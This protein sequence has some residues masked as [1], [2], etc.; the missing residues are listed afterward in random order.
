MKP[1]PRLLL[2]FLYLAI[3]LATTFGQATPLTR[4]T[5]IVTAWKPGQHLYV[6]GDLGLSAGQLTELE[7]WLKTNGPNWMIILLRNASGEQYTAPDG[8]T[9]HG[10]DAVERAANTG[11]RNKTG[12]GQLTDPRTGETNGAIFYLFLTERKFSYAG[13]EVHNNR[14]LSYTSWAGNLDQPAFRAMSG[15]GRIVDAVKGTV[16]E[17]NSRLTRQFNLEQ[18]RRQREL[19]N[20]RRLAQNAQEQIT[21]AAAQIAA[22]EQESAKFRAAHPLATGDLVSPPV[23][24]LQAKLTAARDALARKDAASASQEAKS[25]LDYAKTYLSS[26]TDYGQAPAKFATLNTE[27]SELAAEET[28]WG[29][30]RLNEARDQFAKAQAV[31]ARGDSAYVLHFQN[32]S[33]ALNSALQE[34]DRAKAE[35]ARAAAAARRQA[36][37]EAEFRRTAIGAVILVSVSALVGLIMFLYSLHQGRLDEKDAAI[38]VFN[39]WV[40]SIK[41]QTDELFHLLDRNS[42]VIG[43]A[44]S[45]PSKGYTGRT[46]EL[47]EQTVKDIDSLFIMSSSV[48]RVVNEA[49]ALIFPSFFLLALYNLF[50]PKRYLAALRR[51]KDEPIRFKPEDGV[52]PIQRS[53]SVSEQPLRTADQHESFEL[54]FTELIDSCHQKASRARAA[55]DTLEKSWST[56]NNTLD[57]LQSSQAQLT[58]RQ[59]DV[60]PLLPS[61]FNALLPA[62]QKEM[63]AAIQQAP[64]DP[65]G[66]LEAP[67]NRAQ[68]L[69]N[70]AKALA[71]AVMTHRE[72]QLPALDQHAA[73]LKEMAMKLDW[74]RRADDD[75]AVEADAIAKDAVQRDVSTRIASLETALRQLVERAAQ[76]VEL[77]RQAKGAISEALLGAAASVR[78][79]RENFAKTLRLTPSEMLAEANYNPDDALAEA[80]RQHAASLAGL[81]R[82]DVAAAGNALD[83]AANRIAAAQALV[84][85]SRQS[86]DSHQARIRKLREEHLKLKSQVTPAAVHLK[87]L[88]TRFLPTALRLVRGQ[89]DT[90]IEDNISATEKALSES[91]TVMDTADDDFKA[92]RLLAAAD[93]LEQTAHLFKV[94]GTHLGEITQHSS[95]LDRAE[96]DNKHELTR[97][98]S[99]LEAALAQ[100][101]DPRTMS[102]TQALH[103]TLTGQLEAAAQANRAKVHDPFEIASQL[104]QLTAALG[105]F[106]SRVQADWKLHEEAVRSLRAARAH[107]QQ[108]QELVKRAA[109]DEIPDS[110]ATGDLV[111]EIAVLHRDLRAAEARESQPHADWKA[112]DTIAD[113]IAAAAERATARLKNELDDAEKTVQAISAAATSVR[114]AADWF[115]A[116]GVTIPGSPGS[117][118]LQQARDLLLRGSYLNALR[119]AQEAAADAQRAVTMAEAE[120]SRRRREEEAKEAARRRAAAARRASSTWSSGGGFGGGSSSGGRSSFGG[121]SGSGRS[122]F[123][124]GSGVGRSGW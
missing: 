27:L 37:V 62:A 18:E 4:A 111:H 55:L 50:S 46:R 63:D 114:D 32:A 92:A 1:F 74:L 28:P 17:V 9:Y 75:L 105:E 49:R 66:A 38:Q 59:E 52:E 113:Q 54:T 123:G 115:G 20:A 24:D 51:L 118:S 89:D 47:S 13:G 10:M 94:A 36:Q 45:L 80:N 71:E 69:L 33:A 68:R 103:A 22:I 87:Q 73:A 85:E 76:A 83:T 90:T 39:S 11:A 104:A 58:V 40:Q 6:K 30:E 108:A 12:F 34:I 72:Q 98:K 2:G 15:G 106:S 93:R 26:L 8:Q 79:A 81:D 44:A 102:A 5:D 117:G 112:L 31:H 35:A 119:Q 25:V 86:L 107:V 60:A 19:E 53:G 16:N 41:G 110:Q 65:V 67:A 82:G 43:S 56:V 120:V 64:S 3:P 14:G 97:L 116:Y 7:A 42:Q 48:H 109:A 124:G 78:E 23:T 70:D 29:Q 122:S 101:N 77:T 99:T 100:A 88:Q 57:A 96:S 61:L 95:A 121:G 21:Q 84:A 91:V